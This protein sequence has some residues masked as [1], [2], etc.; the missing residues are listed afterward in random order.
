MTL[1]TRIISLRAPGFGYHDSHVLNKQR[2]EEKE[3]PPRAASKEGADLAGESG[4]P[5]CRRLVTAPSVQGREGRKGWACQNPLGSTQ[6]LVCA[7]RDGAGWQESN[8]EGTSGAGEEQMP[9]RAGF[10][11]PLLRF[12]SLRP[13]ASGL[14]SPWQ[15]RAPQQPTL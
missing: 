15:R 3:I 14:T 11:I 9:D 8:T 2:I 12:L 6:A 1:W 10:A 4:P 7:C 13:R 5:A